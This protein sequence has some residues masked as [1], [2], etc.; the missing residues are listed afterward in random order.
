MFEPIDN[1]YGLSNLILDQVSVGVPL[2]V[3]IQNYSQK[4]D[5]WHPINGDAIEHNGLIRVLRDFFLRLE[6]II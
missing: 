3:F 1:T 2:K 5:L 6:N 4:F